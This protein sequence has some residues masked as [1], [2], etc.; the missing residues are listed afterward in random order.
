MYIGSIVMRIVAKR[1]GSQAAAK[2]LCTHQL[3]ELKV[4]KQNDD[5][6]SN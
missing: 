3:A 2:W 6:F 5:Q 1:S 4:F